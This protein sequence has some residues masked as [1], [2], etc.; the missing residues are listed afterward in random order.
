MKSKVFGNSGFS[1][2]Q[3]AGVRT[4]LGTPQRLKKYLADTLID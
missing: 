4:M 3:V 2:S 1:I